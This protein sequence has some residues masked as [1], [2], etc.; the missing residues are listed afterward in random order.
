MNRR[1]PRAGRLGVPGLAAALGLALAGVGGCGGSPPPAPGP[2]AVK[3]ADAFRIDVADA[4]I[5]Y[6]FWPGG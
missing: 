6:D 3:L 4:D 1:L 2:L 5:T